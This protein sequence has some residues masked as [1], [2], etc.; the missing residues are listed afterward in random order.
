M[1]SKLHLSHLGKVKTKYRA[2]SVFYWPNMT[3]DI[4]N[5][6]SNCRSCVIFSKSPS[7][8]PLINHPIPTRAWQ[9]IGIDL[10]ELYGKMYLVIVDYFSKFVEL[11]KLHKNTTSE[12]IILHL[13]ETFSML[14]IPDEIISDNGPQFSSNLF[15]DF[16][17]SW[18]FQHSTSSPL[19]PQSNGQVERTVGTIKSILK[20][21]FNDKTDPYLAILELRNTPID[22]NLYSP[23]QLLLHRNLKSILPVTEEHLKSKIIKNCFH[24]NNLKQKQ[25]TQKMYFDCKTRKLNDLSINQKVLIKNHGHFSLPGKIVN[26]NHKRRSY[27][28]EINDT[29]KIVTRNRHQIKLDPEKP[30]DFQNSEREE[31]D[32]DFYVT[33]FGRTSKPPIRFNA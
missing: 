14:G 4:D 25:K 7:K 24:R 13:K 21:C 5:L 33:K 9:K 30:L 8:E 27:D 26:V 15:R 20:K 3:R 22:N 16:A 32:G 12:N 10:F 19:F 23:A 2:R 28:I 29:N 17:K 1:L 11:K 31:N 18:G 6:I